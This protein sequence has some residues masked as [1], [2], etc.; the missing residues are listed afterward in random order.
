M[1]VDRGNEV[2]RQFGLV[3]KVPDKLRELYIQFGI[4]LPKFN[5][6]D[7]W[8]L[9]MPGSFVV[10]KSGIIR[11]ASADPDYTIRPEPAELVEVVK[12]L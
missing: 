11:Y 5:G 1:L 3:Y 8:E 10:D 2:A 9:P 6:D 7:S 4:D 12:G